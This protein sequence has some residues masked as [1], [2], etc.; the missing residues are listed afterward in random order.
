MGREPIWDLR[1]HG[2]F[3]QGFQGGAAELRRLES[4]LERRHSPPSAPASP[5]ADFP[6]KVKMSAR[7]ASAFIFTAIF[8]PKPP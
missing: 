8:V 7:S 1:C 3:L 6:Y 2:K 4:P 5:F